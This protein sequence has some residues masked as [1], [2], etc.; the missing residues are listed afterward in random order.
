MYASPTEEMSRLQGPGMSV[1][2]EDFYR[3][4]RY[5]DLVDLSEEE[6]QEKGACHHAYNIM[7]FFFLPPCT[8]IPLSAMRALGIFPPAT[9]NNRSN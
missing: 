8:L 9:A 2:D 7:L 6:W 3:E 1:L 5:S 4:G